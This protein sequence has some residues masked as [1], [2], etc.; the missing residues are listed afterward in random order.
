MS[1]T[2]TPGREEVPGGWEA[3]S[4][5][6]PVAAEIGLREKSFLSMQLRLADSFLG[7]WKVYNIN[8]CIM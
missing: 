7:E 1:E 8:K 2:D 5:E 3:K 4:T 6:A